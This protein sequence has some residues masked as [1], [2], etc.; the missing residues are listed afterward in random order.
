M[1][2]R[3]LI[4]LIGILRKESRE[5]EAAIWLDAAKTDLAITFLLTFPAK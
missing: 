2:N 4:D 5:K 3:E 1:T